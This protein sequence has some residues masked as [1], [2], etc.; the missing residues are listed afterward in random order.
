MLTKPEPRAKEKARAVRKKQRDY[1]ALRVQV[2]HRDMGLCRVC[3]HYASP[4]YGHVHH[5]VYRS[6][7]GEDTM[8]NCLWLCA[9]CHDLE[10]RHRI[11]ITGTSDALDIEVR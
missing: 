3:R 6:A 4:T 7:G 9:T 11:A 8:S 2:C 10:H 1:S 5:I